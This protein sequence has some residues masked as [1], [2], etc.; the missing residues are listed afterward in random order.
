MIF[1]SFYF[2]RDDVAAAAAAASVNGKKRLP[3]SV[4]RFHKEFLDRERFISV[5]FLFRHNED[6]KI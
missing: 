1:R 6:G 3:F 5:A 4:F 2:H